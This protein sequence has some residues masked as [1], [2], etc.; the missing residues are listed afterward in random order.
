MVH[1][2]EISIPAAATS[3]NGPKPYTLY[4]IS[5]RQP[6]RT[7]TIQKRYSDFLALHTALTSQCSNVP[8]PAA[9]PQKSWFKST[10][11]SPEL[12]ESRRR[13]LETYLQA[14]AQASDARWRS[15]AAWRNFLGL[16]SG[17]ALGGGGGVTATTAKRGAE[18]QSAIMDPN[19]WLDVH[20]ELKTQLRD[21]RLHLAKRDQAVTA[22]AQREAGVDAKG[23]LV[24]SG[25]MMAALEKGLQDMSSKASAAGGG[26]ARKGDEGD[27]YGGGPKLGE[28]EIRRRHDLLTAA[29]KERD[30]LDEL[31]NTWAA[32]TGTSEATE[33]AA[34]SAGDKQNLFKAANGKAPAGKRVLGAPLKE[35]ERT[36]ELDNAGV[37]QLQKQVMQ[38]QEADVEDLTKVVR[39]MRDMGA[40][41]N[42]ELVYQN[43]MLGML[44]QDVERVQDKVDVAKKRVGKIK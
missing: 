27:D 9:L 32:R 15:C 2:L 1:P 43:K 8:P 13:G 16:G 34:A 17:N 41:I 25:T 3:H 35:T 33:A 10:T 28:G 30:G 7:S 6:L 36:R 31:S 19:V 37:L 5:I 26:A 44:D 11:S 4:T 38:E 40:Q 42:E 39:R 29:R 12:T 21:A 14:I 23:C 22:Q 18:L 20:R 24:R